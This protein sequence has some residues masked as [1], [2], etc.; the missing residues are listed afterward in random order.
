MP[1]PVFKVEHTILSV[2][3]IKP[4][5]YNPR[6]I[7]PE[8]RAGLKTSIDRFGLVQEVVVNK[9]T[10]HVVGG[11]Q[12]FDVLK[13]SGA[14]EVP[15]ALVD[16]S[17][18]EEKVLNVSLNNPKIQGEFTADLKNLLQGLDHTL[19][20]G[21]RTNELADSLA[22]KLEEADEEFNKE[23]GLEGMTVAPPPKTVWVLAA[24]PT[25]KWSEVSALMEKVAKTEGVQYDSVVR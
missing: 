20:E 24:V 15:V 5:P 12:R 21:L 1:K 13:E 23:F 16:I 8:A 11:N 17:E 7:T 18:E 2:E 19:T 10:M 9:R 25:E 22:E 3:K 14:K 4:S 6:K